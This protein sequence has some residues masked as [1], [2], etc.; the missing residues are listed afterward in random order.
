MK[1]LNE[2]KTHI[3]IHVGLQN[4]TAYIIIIIIPIFCH[5]KIRIIDFHGG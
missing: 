2:Y 4:C 3:H 5:N 1:T